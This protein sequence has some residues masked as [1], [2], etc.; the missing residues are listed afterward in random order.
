MDTGDERIDVNCYLKEI[1][2]LHCE[3]IGYV[4]SLFWSDQTDSI[5]K[6]MRY[7]YR[8]VIKP[9][10]QLNMNKLRFET[11]R[12]YSESMK[13]ISKM[14]N[15]LVPGADNVYFKNIIFSR[16]D[17]FYNHVKRNIYRKNWYKKLIFLENCYRLK[18]A[19]T[20]YELKKV[21]QSQK[22]CLMSS[23]EAFDIGMAYGTAFGLLDY[24]QKFSVENSYDHYHKIAQGLK[25]KYSVFDDYNDY[26]AAREVAIVKW[27]QGD[28]CDH[29]EMVEY[30]L[31]RPEFS[32][33]KKN[34]LTKFIVE[35]AKWYNRV[36]GMKGFKKIE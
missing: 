23:Q 2:A 19:Y 12:E 33:L 9:D 15:T 1:L 21:I 20:I 18:G 6:L 10:R 29:L 22:F 26:K 24:S 5:V 34:I 3:N 35:V 25:K 7:V 8:K 36:R 28:P 4:Q 30:L 13:I 16:I 31:N 11:S 32:H 14:M 27:K 17:D